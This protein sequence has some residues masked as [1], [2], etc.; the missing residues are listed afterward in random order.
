MSKMTNE[1]NYNHK[2]EPIEVRIKKD[3]NILKVALYTGFLLKENSFNV[4]KLSTLGKAVTNLF[5][6][7]EY[8]RMRIPGV[9]SLY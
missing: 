2:K 6:V 5:E 8:V 3:A 7:A 9:H 4:V 1:K